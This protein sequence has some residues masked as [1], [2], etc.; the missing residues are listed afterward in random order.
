[1]ND[2]EGEQV[3]EQLEGIHDLLEALVSLECSCCCKK[4]D[5]ECCITEEE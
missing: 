3:L 4:C 1:M 5:C 2:F